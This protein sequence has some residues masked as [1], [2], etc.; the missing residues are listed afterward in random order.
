MSFHRFPE[1]R[2]RAGDKEDE[3]TVEASNPYLRQQLEELD[4][5]IEYLGSDKR[6]SSRRLE[7]KEAKR[8]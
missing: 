5:G 6:T 3:N 2:I 1:F 4:S 8:G 7:K